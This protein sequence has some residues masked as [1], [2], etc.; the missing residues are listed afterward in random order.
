MAGGHREGRRAVVGVIALLAADARRA[1]AA[2]ESAARDGAD[3]YEEIFGA[4]G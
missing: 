4:A 3:V 2:L 1:A